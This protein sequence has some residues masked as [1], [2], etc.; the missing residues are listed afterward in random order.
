MIF[1]ALIIRFSSLFGGGG[2]NTST[3]GTV[4]QPIKENCA[5]GKSEGKTICSKEVWV[6]V[7]AKHSSFRVKSKWN[8]FGG[9]CT[10]NVDWK[11]AFHYTLQ[12]WVFPFDYMTKRTRRQRRIVGEEL[13]LVRVL[14]FWFFKNRSAEQLIMQMQRKPLFIDFHF[15]LFTEEVKPNHVA[16]SPSLMVISRSPVHIT[17][18]TVTIDLSKSVS[19]PLKM[20][21]GLGVTIYNID[22]SQTSLNLSAESSGYVSNSTTSSLGNVSLNQSGSNGDDL[23]MEKNVSLLDQRLTVPNQ[24]T[25]NALPMP[26]SVSGRRRTISSNSNR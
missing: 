11:N 19:T 18:Q 5:T 25:F 22:E 23:E 12:S 10:G 26:P 17:P 16:T 15:L 24:S 13:S 14:L 21:N 9:G 3:P 6:A 2:T 1:P 8:R 7:Q 4:G 20:T